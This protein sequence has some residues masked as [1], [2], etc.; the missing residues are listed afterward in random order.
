MLVL[1]GLAILKMGR[2]CLEGV[3]MVRF[4]VSVLRTICIVLKCWCGMLINLLS[5]ILQ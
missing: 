1:L 5:N 3:W 4:R 2:C